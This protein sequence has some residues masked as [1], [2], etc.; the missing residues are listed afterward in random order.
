MT[1]LLKNILFVGIKLLK[2]ILFLGTDKQKIDSLWEYH[3]GNDQ[4]LSF[5]HRCPFDIC[6]LLK[7]ELCGQNIEKHILCR[8]MLVTYKK[9][10]QK[11]WEPKYNIV[12]LLKNTKYY[13]SY[14][15]NILWLKDERFC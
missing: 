15:N 9:T 11:L 8:Q 7:R 14:A 6:F 12:N 10:V 3:F 1:E 4:S 2:T 5:V 13:H